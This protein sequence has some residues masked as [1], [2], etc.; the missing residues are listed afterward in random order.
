[1]NNA[2]VC[3]IKSIF[4]FKN[5]FLKNKCN[6]VINDKLLIIILKTL[7]DTITRKVKLKYLRK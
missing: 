4:C 5:L 3:D 1:M 6:L 2:T 7:A